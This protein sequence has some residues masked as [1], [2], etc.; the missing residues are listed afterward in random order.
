MIDNNIYTY[1]PFCDKSIS[2]YFQRVKK[3]SIVTSSKQSL[4]LLEQYLIKN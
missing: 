2:F 4:K 3:F 1:I